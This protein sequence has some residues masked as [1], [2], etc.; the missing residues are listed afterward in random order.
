MKKIYILLSFLTALGWSYSCSDDHNPVYTAGQ[1]VSG[2]IITPQ[3]GKEYVLEIDKRYEVIETFQWSRTEYSQPLGVRYSLQA[4]VEDG[5]FESP[6]LLASLTTQEVSFTGEQLNAAMEKL[7]L[8]PDVKSLVKLRLASNAYGGEEGNVPLTQFPT[9]SSEVIDI[10]V[11]PYEE[12]RA[13]PENLYMI[14]DEFSDGNWSWDAEGVV[15]LIPVHGKEGEFWCINYFTAGKEF[16]WAPK[17]AWAN[18]FNALD[19]NTGFVLS[20]GNAAVEA[21]GVY[22]V[23]IN[24]KSS[25]IY[26]EPAQVYGI[27]DCFGGWSAEPIL[28][29]IAGDKITQTTTGT[30]GLRMYAGSSIATSDWWTREFV[31]MDGKI[32]YRAGGDELAGVDV[33]AGKTVRLD[34]RAGT[35]IIN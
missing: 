12:E 5:N 17:R 18:D 4:D 19:T 15:Q 32:V 33:A 7:G 16:K 23:Y 20:G 21:D 10:Y 6:V 3:T 35:G 13:Y 28:F 34:F 31:I 8:E 2:Q 1:E 9:L 11:T 14:G 22:M 29:N 27:G 24:M 30:G 26:I 25:E